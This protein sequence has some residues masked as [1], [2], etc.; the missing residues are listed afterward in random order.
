[1]NKNKEFAKV[2]TSQEQAI[3]MRARVGTSISVSTGISCTMSLE[4]K[5]FSANAAPN[6]GRN[7]RT[8][9]GL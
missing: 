6:T 3:S 8:I 7:C 4:R 2:R 1:V 9:S 5:R